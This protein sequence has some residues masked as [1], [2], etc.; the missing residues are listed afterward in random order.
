MA[1][2]REAL[3]ELAEQ[4]REL[5]AARDEISALHAQAATWR[6][7]VRA[8]EELLR[9][10]ITKWRARADEAERVWSTLL[11]RDRVRGIEFDP[12]ALDN[13][14]I[15]FGDTEEN[16]VPVPKGPGNGQFLYGLV[17]LSA[18]P[19]SPIFFRV[20]RVKPQ[21]EAPA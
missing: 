16:A 20:E 4:L 5:D 12:R 11:A 21:L 14:D 10:E 17:D 3:D 6:E 15:V 13:L 1:D 9:A 8:N 19:N 18:R 2:W 7:R